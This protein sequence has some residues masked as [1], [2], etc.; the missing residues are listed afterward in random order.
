LRSR[1]RGCDNRD[2]RRVA[3]LKEKYRRLSF[4]RVSKLLNR[5][6]VL[7]L[8][9][10]LLP[11]SL[12]AAPPPSRVYVAV[13]YGG[14]RLRSTDGV[15]WEIAA[16]WTVNGGDDRNNLISVAYGNG[17][18]VAVG[19]GVT[20]KNGPGGRI[21]TSV[22]GKDW[23]ELPGWKF[24]VHPVLFGNGRFVAGGPDYQLLWSADGA[25]WEPGGKI[26]DEAATHFRMGA[27]GNGVFVFAGNGR[28]AEQ[29][30]HWVVCSRDGTAIDAERSDLPPLRAMAFGNGRFVVV[31]P[32]GLRLSSAD[33]KTWENEVREP[34]VTLDSVVW[35]GKEF[36]AAG[37]GKGFASADGKTWTAWPKPVPCSVLLADAAH[38]VWIG[39]SWPGTMWSSADGL[40]WTRAKPMTPNG[41]N[42]VAMG[43]IEQ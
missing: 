38:G 28:R 42:S 2:F 43:E 19:G 41:I 7:A 25:T 3:T 5:R 9:L 10:V 14:R 26:A 21:L 23:K 30:I 35:T 31:G 11:S 33:G 13:G 40:E 29:E 17:T 6:T 39:S 24:R 16:D 32:D 15:N 34:K 8:P 20:D 22:D 1:K 27:F 36:F 37:D 12:G 4:T 18:F